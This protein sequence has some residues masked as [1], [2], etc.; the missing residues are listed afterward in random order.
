MLSERYKTSFLYGLM[1]ILMDPTMHLFLGLY[2]KY[3]RPRILKDK[4]EG[5]SDDERFV[6]TSSREDRQKAMSL[7]SPIT[8]KSEKEKKHMTQSN[9][10]QAMSSTWRQS[11]VVSPK[12][13]SLISNTLVRVSCASYA[14]SYG[15][16]GENDLKT[17]ANTF[18]K[19][20]ELT[21]RKHYIVKN[22]LGNQ[23]LRYNM[24]VYNVFGHCSQVK[25]FAEKD[26]RFANTSAEELLAFVK[27]W[28]EDMFSE[29]SDK[30]V[31][32]NTMLTYLQDGNQKGN[33]QEDKE[34]LEDAEEEDA[35]EKE[36][37]VNGAK[38][39]ITDHFI[40][41]NIVR[42]NDFYILNKDTNW[43]T[44]SHMV[45]CAHILR[46]YFGF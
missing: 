21:T 19:N 1:Y 34:V 43:L 26:L 17:F 13:A 28:L 27:G 24:N 6:F 46:C 44:R 10:A 45:M 31:M 40:K 41:Y 30:A 14:Y 37:N 8:G 32:D 35:E 15:L 33:E 18:M 42:A 39:I 5:C 36:D 7:V 3:F 12:R 20:K 11:K 16:I 23:G 2:I 38:V 22:Y 4:E 25:R 29:S 9:V